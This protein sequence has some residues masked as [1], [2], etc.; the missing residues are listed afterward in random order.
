M[1]V[2]AAFDPGLSN[3]AY[4]VMS[5]K[6]RREF[7]FIGDLPTMGAKTK[8][9]LNGAM[10][11]TNLREYQVS[12]VVI[13]H[14]SAMPKQG[15]SSM[16]RFGMAYGQIIGIVQGLMLPYEIVT[17]AKWK[18]EMRLNTDKENSRL[19]AIELYPKFHEALKRVKDHNRAEAMLLARW[20]LDK[21]RI[22]VHEEIEKKQTGV[23][24]RIT[25]V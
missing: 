16:F 8:K 13:E 10:I 19:R 20:W 22:N 18:K 6:L 25:N 11:A 3:G 7:A 4:A 9:V 17:P 12:H 24:R 2:L 14:A 23:R 5:D 1:T 15:V 21:E